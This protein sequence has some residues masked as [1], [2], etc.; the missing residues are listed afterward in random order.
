MA[1]TET[2]QDAVAPRAVL[3]PL[4][5]WDQR[6]L[7]EEPGVEA[8]CAEG[9]LDELH[10]INCRWLARNRP[11]PTTGVIRRPW[12][13]ACMYRAI[14]TGHAKV[15]SYLLSTGF[16]ISPVKKRSAHFIGR[17]LKARSTAVLQ[18]FLDHGWDINEPTD[19]IYPSAL[20]YA[21][22]DKEMTEWFLAHK[23]SPN[24]TSSVGTTPLSQACHKGDFTIVQLLF[25]HGGDLKHGQ[26]LHWAARRML[27]DRIDLVAFLLD[28]GAPINAIMYETYE[29]L[30]SEECWIGLG[31]PLHYA[32]ERGDVDLVKVLLARGADPLIKD[33]I[34]EGRLAKDWAQATIDAIHYDP[35]TDPRWK[36][37]KSYPSLSETVYPPEEN[38]REIVRILEPWWLSALCNWVLAPS[39]NGMKVSH[40]TSP[41][42]GHKKGHPRDT[43]PGTL[44]PSPGAISALGAGG[45]LTR[46]PDKALA[47]QPAGPSQELQDRDSRVE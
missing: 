17:A 32:A 46:V 4:Q 25:E 5:D 24:A 37:M 27:P 23:A 3:F 42:P 28:K 36:D 39:S 8:A 9:R 21:I 20:R 44:D 19:R 12:L 41:T 33:S 14:D 31:T 38:L 10:D 47:A 11:D 16:V 26:L 18:A 22:H 40:A 30:Y 1:N 6:A 43:Y 2:E 7:D 15:V 34:D 29:K 13:W 35:M 45:V